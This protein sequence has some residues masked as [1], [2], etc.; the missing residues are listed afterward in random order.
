M[1]NYLLA[2]GGTAGHVN[3]LLAVADKLKAEQPDSKIL[4]LGTAQGLEA[5]LVPERGY[6][7]S[8]IDKVP[9]PRRLSFSIFRFPF[10]LKA[11]VAEVRALI[12]ERGINSVVGF[13]GFVSAPAYLASWL[14]KVPFVVHEANAIPGFANRLGSRLTKYVGVAFRGTKLAHSRFVGMPMR[15]EI[16]TLDRERSRQQ[17]QAHFGLADSRKTWL[18]TGGSLGA[19]GINETI[20]NSGVLITGADWNLLHILG[21]TADLPTSKSKFYRPILYSDRMD[22]AFAAADFVISRAGSA[23]IA[24]LTGLGIPAALVPYE[25]GNGEQVKNTVDVVKAGGAVMVRNRDFTT[26]WIETDLLDLIENDA[27][28]ARMAQASKSV[29]LLDGTE[30]VLA[31]IKES[32]GLHA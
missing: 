7:L 4:V 20:S 19:R 2:G 31:L 25:S 1:T 12:R 23:T 17:A 26:K 22:L 3:P 16:E 15:I 9:L 6:E 11:L 24:E 29:G 18:V 32:L 10:R 8:T 5:R 30:R 14:E 28:L 21:P 13:G 27:K